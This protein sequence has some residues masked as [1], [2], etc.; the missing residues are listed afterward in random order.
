MECSSK[1][2]EGVED[3]LIHAARLSIRKSSNYP[4]R[5]KCILQ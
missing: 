3:L 5:C 4:V 2:G 1:T